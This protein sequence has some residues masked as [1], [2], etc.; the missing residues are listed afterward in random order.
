M[1]RKARL[2][3]PLKNQADETK[4]LGCHAFHKD[5]IMIHPSHPSYANPS[6][7]RE[8]RESNAGIG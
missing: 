1:E 5:G 4:L 6:I 3:A 2:D 8:A 7:L